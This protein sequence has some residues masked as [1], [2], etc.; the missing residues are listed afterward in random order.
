LVRL[1]QPFHA[2]SHF[3]LLPTARRLWRAGHGSCRLVALERE[4]LSFLRGPDIPGAMIPRT[5]F[6]YLQRRPAPALQS[7]FTHNVHDVVSLAAL[8]VHACDRIAL[9]P[10]AL[11]EP[12]DLYSLARVL[13]N[14]SDWR[15][16]VR[17]YEMAVQGGL[18]EPM[19]RKAVECL[20]VACR[21]VG[22]HDRTLELCTELMGYEEFSMI[23][24]EGAVI[25][26]ERV[27]NDLDRALRFLAE[28]LA[29]ADSKRS[30]VVL[31]ARW[32]RLCRKRSQLSIS[33]CNSSHQ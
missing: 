23:G 21:R 31:Q 1:D 16:A 4:M 26:Y 33:L 18:P 13:Q 14:S 3:D 6:D 9:E 19:R 30:K 12:L 25:Y 8:T 28:G 15:R 11:D 7:I 2:I 29:R 32:D 17:L 22:D 5:Y 10:A 24:Y 20:A 27:A